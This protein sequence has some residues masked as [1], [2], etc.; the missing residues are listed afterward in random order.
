M[1][2]GNR[3]NLRERRVGFGQCPV[4]DFSDALGV[5]PSRDF[6]DH[7]PIGFVQLI[8]RLHHRGEDAVSIFDHRCRGLITTG[9]KPQNLHG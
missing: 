9:F 7:T 4:G 1:G 3:I 6:R 5:G 8:L 2:Y